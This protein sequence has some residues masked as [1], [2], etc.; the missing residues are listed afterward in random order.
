MPRTQCGC[1]W[2][3]PPDCLAVGA[4]A[5]P[6]LH[7][8][9]LRWHRLLWV[10]VLLLLLLLLVVVVVFFCHPQGWRVPQLLRHAALQQP[11]DSQ[12]RGPTAAPEDAWQQKH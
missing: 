5:T 4:D 6:R 10:A 2:V 11:H 9:G 8:L 3:H 12:Q 1:P 7:M